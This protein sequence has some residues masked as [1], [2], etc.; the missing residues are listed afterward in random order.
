MFSSE[1]TR[2]GAGSTWGVSIW[3]TK[4]APTKFREG[5]FKSNNTIDVGIDVVWMPVA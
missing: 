1:E 3:G 5:R 2:E 4:N